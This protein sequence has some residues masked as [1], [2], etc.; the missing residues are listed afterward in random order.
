MKEIPWCLFLMIHI[1]T[2]A[3]IAEAFNSTSRYIDDIL[4]ID[5]ICVESMVSQNYLISEL[6]LSKAYT[7]DT[8]AP[9]LDY[10]PSILIGVVSSKIHDTS[11]GV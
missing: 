3:D 8:E 5:N 2:Q 6:Q 10:H 4:D 9:L 11:Y 1:F 7:A